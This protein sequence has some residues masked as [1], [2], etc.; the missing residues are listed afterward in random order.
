[1]EGLSK[2]ISSEKI[3]SIVHEMSCP[4]RAW[5]AITGAFG[6][7]SHNRY[8]YEFYAGLMKSVATSP[9]RTFV[10]RTEH[11][12]SDWNTVDYMFGGNGTAGYSCS[13]R[14]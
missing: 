14:V 4:Q 10:L 9:M 2:N 12:A 3:P 6:F 8:N 13:G 11:L 5:A 1:M 7:A